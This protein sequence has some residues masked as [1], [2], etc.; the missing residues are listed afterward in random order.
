MV[1][2]QLFNKTHLSKP[3]TFMQKCNSDEENDT[4]ISIIPFTNLSLIIISDEKT[5]GI[6]LDDL[7]KQIKM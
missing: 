2:Y 1:I 5:H 4:E 7:Q 6:N 3:F